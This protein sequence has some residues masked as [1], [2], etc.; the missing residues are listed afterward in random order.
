MPNFSRANNRC[1]PW[2]P[3]AGGLLARPKDQETA[4]S[5]DPFLKG[6]TES[7]EWKTYGIKI[8]DRVQELAKKKGVTMAQLATAWVLSNDGNSIYDVS[9]CSRR[10]GYCRTEFQ[11]ATR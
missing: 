1:I 10:R 5:S 2:W 11:E 6:I 8:V 3:L 9:N 7:K 4:R